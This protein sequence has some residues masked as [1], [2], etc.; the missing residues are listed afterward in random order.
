[1]HDCGQLPA[2]NFDHGIYVEHASG[3]T[4]VDNQV[5]DNADRGIQL[6]PDAQGTY[7]ARN[8]IDGNGEGVLIAG[9]S[10]D[11]GS[12]ASN[13]N[14]VEQNLITNSSQRNNV[15]SRWDPGLVGQRNVLRNNC[16]YGGALDASNHGLAA[17]YGFTSSGNVMGDPRYVN[18]AGGDFRLRPESGCLDLAGAAAATPAAADPVPRIVV[19]AST[20]AT[21]PGGAFVLSGEVEGRRPP[22]CVVLKAR[23][24][25]RW[26]RV[27]RVR[28]K[29]DGRFSTKLRVRHRHRRA[30]RSGR[31][32]HRL[33]SAAVT[34]F[35]K[36]VKLT[37]FAPGFRRSNTVRVRVRARRR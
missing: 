34:S 27:A 20:T 35:G 7:I 1:V 31:R 8:V 32:C 6:Y 26:K 17:D 5:Y 16:I 23:R 33:R 11:Y 10:E 4:I 25:K 2:T 30:A 19:S 29:R 9:G 14:V 24:G 21:S 15:E 28:V 22:T 36:A 18:R 12:Q 3:A 13:D 37:A